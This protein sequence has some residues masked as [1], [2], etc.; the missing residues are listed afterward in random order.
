MFLYVI[1]MMLYFASNAKDEVDVL[2][3][4]KNVLEYLGNLS[5]IQIPFSNMF[6]MCLQLLC[7]YLYLRGNV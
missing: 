5:V 2:H 3:F 6:K 7:E 4:S 1:S